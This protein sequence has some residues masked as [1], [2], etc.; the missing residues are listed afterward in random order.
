MRATKI[1]ILREAERMKKERNYWKKRF[2]T[3][4]NKLNDP[5]DEIFK[6][7]LFSDIEINILKKEISL[8]KK[9]AFLKFPDEWLTGLDDIRSDKKLLDIYK[10]GFKDGIRKTL[11]VKNTKEVKER[12]MDVEEN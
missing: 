6:C 8:L 10:W 2:E 7:K 1:E 11:F 3:L 5:L 9:N 12:W 4:H